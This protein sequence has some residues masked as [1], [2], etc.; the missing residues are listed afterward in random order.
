MRK[1]VFID[2]DGTLI[3]NVPYNADPDKIVLEY[4]AL[5]GLRLLQEKGYALIVVSNQ[6]GIA[7]GYFREEDMLPVIARVREL[8]QE[9]GITLDGFYYCPHHPAGKIT[10]YALRCDCRKPLPGMLLQAAEEM[11]IFLPGSWMIGDILNDV[12]AGNRAGCRSVLLNNGNET[13]WETNDYNKPAHIANDMLEAARLIVKHA[14]AKFETWNL[15]IK[16]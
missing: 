6:A 12:E 10:P 1:A 16:R 9:G 4:G 14:T 3:S 7:H 11:D 8:L 5:E 13:V 2:K 15:Y